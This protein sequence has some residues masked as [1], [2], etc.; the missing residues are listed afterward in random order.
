[1]LHGDFTMERIKLAGLYFDPLKLDEAVKAI[2]DIVAADRE[3]S[4]LV[5]TP[6]VDHVLRCQKNAEVASIYHRA[7]LSLA[8]G[9]PLVWLSKIAGRPLPERVTGADLLPALA[10]AA[11]ER[12]RSVFLFGGPEGAAELAAER[13]REKSP[14][15]KVGW[16]T[17]PMGFEKDPGT[18]TS[19]I[20]AINDFGPDILFVGLGSPKQEMW[21]DRNAGQ[22]KVTVSLGVGAAIE[23]A[24]GLLDRAPQWMQAS[25]TEW[26]Y[27]LAKDPRRLAWRY[28]SNLLFIR[29]IINEIMIRAKHSLRIG[30][31]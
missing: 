4:V 13:L 11:A 22:L 7:R 5:V 3:A 14:G 24:A 6:N 12:G 27:R 18:N 10:V 17:P 30:I 21:V 28:L 9:M 19:A 20:R 31:R 23:F 26:I 15:L 25:G 29:F 2:M 16:H 1:M 8:D